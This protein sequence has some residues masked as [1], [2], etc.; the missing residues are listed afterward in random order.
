MG[1]VIDEVEAKKTPCLCY[2]LKNGKVLCHTKGIV[3]FLSDEQKK[4]YCYGTYVRPATSEMEER[5]QQF[6]EQ[7]R[8]CSEQV[9][10]EFK[11]GDRLLPFLDCMS[12]EGVE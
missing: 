9:H 1:I 3:G 7:A 6:A 5:L 11:R 2:E 4:N 12:K 10:G 8:R